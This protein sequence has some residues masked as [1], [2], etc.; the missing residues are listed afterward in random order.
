MNIIEH[1]WDHLKWKVHAQEPQP[2]NLD[3][4]W[5][6]VEEEWYKIGKDVV[7]QLYASLPDRVAALKKAHG[8]NTDY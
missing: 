1:L 5:A 8:G 2:S 4:L 7:D 6:V 3:E